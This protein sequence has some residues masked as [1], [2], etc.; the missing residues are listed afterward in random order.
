[1]ESLNF[2]KYTRILL[3]FKLKLDNAGIDSTKNIVELTNGNSAVKNEIAGIF[4]NEYNLSEDMMGKSLK[5]INMYMTKS[6]K[7]SFGN[8]MAKYINQTINESFPSECKGNYLSTFANENQ[9]NVLE[10]NNLKLYIIEKMNRQKQ[11][12]QFIEKAISEYMNSIGKASKTSATS[13]NTSS[14]TGQIDAVLLEK[15]NKH[16]SILKSGAEIFNKSYSFPEEVHPE[17]SNKT[18]NSFEELYEE[19]G[20]DFIEG[21]KPIYNVKQNRV[22]DSWENWYKQRKITVKDQIQNYYEPVIT[23]LEQKVV[24]NINNIVCNYYDDCGKKCDLSNDVYKRTLVD[25][26]TNGGIS[27]SGKTFLI[28][29]TGFNSIGES[30]IKY[31][32]QGGGCVVTTT[33]Q[34]SKVAYDRYQKLYQT[35]CARGS[36]L[37]VIPANLASKQD[38]SDVIKYIV[39]EGYNLDYIAPFVA[40]SQGGDLSQIDSKSELVFRLMTTQVLRMIGEYKKSKINNRACITTL[41]VPLSPNIG[42]FG[43]DGLYAESKLALRSLFYKL[44][45]EKMDDDFN[46]IGISI[47]WT[48]TAL[49]KNNDKFVDDVEKLGVKTFSIDEMAQLILLNTSSHIFNVNCSNPIE[50]DYSFGLDSVPNFSEKFMKIVMNYKGT[51]TSEIEK[52]ESVQYNTYDYIKYPDIQKSNDNTINNYMNLD[53]VYVFTGYGEVSPYGSS[54]T[55]WEVEKNKVLSIESI[56]ELAKI[57][58]IK[59]PNPLTSNLNDIFDFYS[60]KHDEMINGCGIREINPEYFMDNYD[61]LNKTIYKKYTLTKDSEFITV[62]DLEEAEQYRTKYGDKCRVFKNGDE[63]VIRLSEGTDIYLTKSVTSNARVAGQL[64]NGWSAK[65]YGIPDDIIKNVDTIALYGLVSTAEAL[66]MSGITDPYEFYE[67]IHM[68]K[69]GNTIGSGIGGQRNLIYGFG[70]R[71]FDKPLNSDIIQEMLIN[72]MPAWINMLL[73]SAS[74]PIVTPVQA[75]ATSATSVDIAVNLLETGKAYIVFVGGSEEITESSIT[76]FRNIGANINSVDDAECGRTPRESSRPCTST[77][78][79]FVESC[80]AGVQILMRASLALKM[81]LPIF[82][83]CAHT[84]TA[85]DKQGRSVP[86]PGKGILTSV[87]EPEGEH[88]DVSFEKRKTE[89]E[90]CIK[91]IPLDNNNNELITT[92]KNHYFHDFWKNKM[93]PLRGALTM[94]GLTAD[95][96]TAVS[97]HG[98][99]TK[100]NDYNESFINSKQMEILGRTPGNPLFVVAQKYLTGHSKGAAFAFML[101]GALDMMSSNIIPGNYNLDNLGSDLTDFKDFVFLNETIYKNIDSILLKSF[102]FGQAGAEVLL[103][104]PKYLYN[105][106]TNDEINDYKMRRSKREYNYRNI[107]NKFI[108]QNEGIVHIKNTPPY[109]EKDEIYKL[110]TLPKNN[111]T[112]DTDIIKTITKS[113]GDNTKSIG[114]DVQNSNEIEFDTSFIKRNFVDEELEQC[115]ENRMRIL[116]KFCAKEAVFKAICNLSTE[117]RVIGNSTKHLNDIHIIN[118]V[119]GCPRVKITSKELQFILKNHKIKVSITYSDTKAYAVAVTI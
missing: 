21:I 97:Y 112:N 61:P 27:W 9:L 65:T 17:S 41:L 7:V 55:R 59:A 88:Y 91:N 46:M 54:R 93:S 57:M 19:I 90:N 10:L 53:R 77:R 109:D 2:D 50:V 22:Y 85:C 110:T 119:S 52:N 14:N 15:I 87:A 100:G 68:S 34:V 84:H 76:E 26:N 56:L 70:Q 3:G 25:I 95:N 105:M 115:G 20:R 24:S 99:S 106:M 18:D 37:V 82:G 116:G 38:T 79:G 66:M 107:Y 60:K 45:S 64:P 102:G 29:G 78:N 40:M 1:M 44:R 32:L 75:C 33:S 80:G 6:G 89:F 31:V 12:K 118:D 103:V 35:N 4:I 71:Q 94:W 13:A 73:L 62:A 114:I 111:F 74:G 81:G 43:N 86:A 28:T 69:L 5:D 11:S 98:T 51:N 39:K 101:N 117:N 30:L 92:L 108:C 23:S 67:Y 96:I 49:M 72:V 16:E 104:H 8:W 47:G 36:K 63:Y 42:I 48:R 113:M 83:I 58:G